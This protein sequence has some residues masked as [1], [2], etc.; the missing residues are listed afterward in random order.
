LGILQKMRFISLC[1]LFNLSWCFAIYAQ[2]DT[3]N[4]KATDTLRQN[5]VQPAIPAPDSAAVAKASREQFME[6]SIAMVYLK[7]DT[8]RLE[9]FAASITKN[10]LFD[11]HS[12][13]PEQQRQKSLLPRGRPRNVRDPWIIVVLTGLLIFTGLLNVFFN[14]DIKIVFQSFYNKHALSQLDKE[15][16]LINSWAFVGLFVLFSLTSGLVLY[17]LTIYYNYYQS[18][19][20][21]R[22]FIA[23]SAAVSILF[24]IKFI[25]LKFIGFVFDIKRQV[26]EYITVLNLTYFNIA[27]VLL[28]VATC[29][30]LLN[31]HLI[32]ALLI[33]TLVSIAAIFAWQYLRKGV[34]IISDFRLHK[35][36]LFIYLCALEICPVLILIKALNI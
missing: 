33:F 36:Y 10:V 2:R 17:Q 15:G 11:V 5:R 13:P 14:R 6:D 22:L 32:P 26:S 20:G 16:G 19:T 25:V 3:A 4:S 18:L 21:I 12:K 24:A 27:F 30:S 29:F 1:L 8:T 31:S 35:F 7:P 9:S 34:S 28:F 23:F